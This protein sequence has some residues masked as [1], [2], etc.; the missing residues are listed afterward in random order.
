MAAMRV[1]QVSI[2]IVITVF[3]A[4]PSYS[5]K[6][7]ATNKQSAQ[8]QVSKPKADQPVSDTRQQN[9]EAVSVQCRPIESQEPANTSK[10]N[11]RPQPIKKINDTLLVIF[12]GAL[13]FVGYL[14]WK[15]LRQHE[16]WMK[17][18]VA[19]ARQAAKSASQS[20]DAARDSTET[21]ISKERARLRVEPDK[22]K[23]EIDQPMHG[24]PITVRHFGPTEAFITDTGISIFL[25]PPRKIMPDFTPIGIPDHMSPSQS[26]HSIV[27]P[28]DEITFSSSQIDAIENGDLL[29]NM[30]G[31]IKYTD[32]FDRSRVTSF[33][34]VW[35][36]VKMLGFDGYWIKQPENNYET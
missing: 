10:E 29:L 19:I 18:N 3:A 1:L 12:T 20:A 23:F 11:D 36:A 31:F 5:Q 33:A 25:S 13:A 8:K 22:V 2:L 16:K 35:H 4:M 30:R 15:T 14:Q 21:I 28:V 17:R 7:A 34:L 27:V 26:K 24:V 32:V 9:T 6:Q